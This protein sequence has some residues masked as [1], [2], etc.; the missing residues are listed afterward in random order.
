MFIW[1]RETVFGTDFWK[2]S[3]WNSV[4]RLEIFLIQ[5]KTTNFQKLNAT[6]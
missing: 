1:E 2:E 6:F 4:A 5:I 3:L